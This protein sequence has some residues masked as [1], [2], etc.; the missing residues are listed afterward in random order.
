MARTVIVR[1]ICDRCKAEG[2]E[3]VE[4]AEEVGFSH[5]GDSYLIDLCTPHA[6]EFHNTIQTMVAWSTDRSK[7]AAPRKARRL[8]G[9]DSAALA[10]SAVQPA[11]RDK[12]Q[13][14]AIR[15]WANANGYKVSNRGRIPAEVEAAYNTSH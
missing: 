4:S 11:R 15:D 8:A 12:E 9:A 6:E 1:S 14:G 2:N 10:R 13:I 5:D 3:E 7:A